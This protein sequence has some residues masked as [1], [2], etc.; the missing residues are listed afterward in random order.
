MDEKMRILKM[1]EEGTLSAEQAVNLID[2][3]DQSNAEGEAKGAPGSSAVFDDQYPAVQDTSSY[4]N[5]ML[6]IVVDSADGDK[7]NIQLPV[8]IIRQVLKL[9][10][11]LP[12][13][14]DGLQGIDL[15]ALTSSILECMDNETLGNIV[16]VHAADGSVVQIFIG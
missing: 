7:V 4:E 12:I 14:S 15:D 9:T 6:R 13:Q 2:A 3:L 16:E 1:I 5:K 10:G 8:K 11:K